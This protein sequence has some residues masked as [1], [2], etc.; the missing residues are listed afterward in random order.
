MPRVKISPLTLLAAAFFSALPLR[1]ES[2][3]IPRIASEWQDLAGRPALAAAASAAAPGAAEVEPGHHYLLRAPRDAAAAA[4]T[5]VYHSTDAANFN[6]DAT[7]ADALHLVAT[8]PAAAQQI[9]KQDGAWFV[10]SADAKF[11][12]L[13][14]DPIATPT[15]PKTRPPGMH[16]RVALYDD[17]G[18]AGKGIPSVSE[19]LG[20][21]G[22]IEVT[23][24]DAAG[25]RAG[26]SG[27]DVV[28]FTGGSGSRQANTIGLLGR[29]Q[30]RRFVEAGGGYVGICAG[31]YLACDGFS[32]GIKILD[33]KTPSPKWERG[34]GDLKIETTD[35]GQSLLGLPHESVVIYHNGPVLTPAHNAAIPD[36]EPLVFFRTEVSKVPEQAGL[37][38]DT[39]AIVRGTFGA[40]RVLVSSP[41]PEQTAGMERWIVRAVRAVA[42]Q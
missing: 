1:A 33:A 10:V 25:I 32:W 24:L 19:Q 8:L 2:L 5:N 12:R 31:A 16:I 15:L 9:V 23:K 38:I 40:G 29:E 17:R 41:H 39:P 28:V 22:D 37:Q 34:H 4:G 18:S 36:F 7:N 30:A 26:L 20:K 6:L 35:A 14:W 27:Y 11:A 42:A 21:A 13:E 3:L